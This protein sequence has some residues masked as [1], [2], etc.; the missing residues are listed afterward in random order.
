MD[1]KS[2]RD[3]KTLNII[4]SG[5]RGKRRPNFFDLNGYESVICNAY[6]FLLCDCD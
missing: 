6:L 2:L 1:G 5:K 4:N 3:L